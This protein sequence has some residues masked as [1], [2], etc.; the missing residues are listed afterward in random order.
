MP[1]CARKGSTNR[2][3]LFFGGGEGAEQVIF[4][5]PTNTFRCS[6]WSI[7]PRH[8]RALSHNMAI[9]DYGCV[10]IKRNGDAI[11]LL[12][13]RFPCIY[14]FPD[15]ETSF[16]NHD[17]FLHIFYEHQIIKNHQLNHNSFFCKTDTSLR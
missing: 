6:V 3:N 2:N 1:C 14:L 4:T 13:T 5:F 9:P 11:V 17:M 8:R 10:V 16:F 15:I 7:R 12:P